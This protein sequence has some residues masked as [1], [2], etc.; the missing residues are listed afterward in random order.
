MSIHLY[1]PQR[2]AIET[3]LNCN[4]G[5]GQIIGDV[6]EDFQTRT[7]GGSR[8]HHMFIGPRGIG[9]TTLLRLIAHHLTTDAD[10]AGRY[11]PVILAE[12]AYGV[13]RVSDLMV[14]IARILSQ[15]LDKAELTSTYEKVRHEE[16]DQRVVD[17]VLDALRD[18]HRNT[19]LSLVL[20][21]ENC[22]RFLERQKRNRQELHLLR[23]IMM[24]EVWLTGIF[25][26]PTYLNAITDHREPFFEFFK[27]TTLGEL[28]P[29]ELLEMLHKL[30]EV[31][32][33]AKFREY[34]Q[35]H[36]SRIRAL[37]HFTGGNPRLA[38]MLYD[39]VTNHDITGV[40]E[41]LDHLLDQITPF[42]QDRM[43]DLSDQEAKA[44]EAMSLIPEGCLPKDLAKQARLEPGATRVLLSRLENAGYI[45]REKRSDRKT[46]YYIPERLFRIWNAMNNSRGEKRKL[47][48]LVDFFSAWYATEEE[49]RYTWEVLTEKLLSTVKNSEKQNISATLEYLS[50]ISSISSDREKYETF[51]SLLSKTLSIGDNNK[52]TSTLLEILKT[53]SDDYELQALVLIYTLPIL[54]TDDMIH[55]EV[56]NLYKKYNDM[57]FQSIIMILFQNIKDKLQMMTKSL[58]LLILNIAKANHRAILDAILTLGLFHVITIT[59]DKYHS[60][61]MELLSP[62]LSLIFGRYNK[63]EINIFLYKSDELFP[64]FKN[65][66]PYA[67]KAY[68]YLTNK[69]SPAILEDLSPELREAAML[70]VKAFDSNPANQP[71]GAAS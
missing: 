6:L 9:K 11:L 70:L 55:K 23:K 3:L 15:D 40:R 67:T 32:D 16:D 41:E 69:R 43:K 60:H 19:G 26:S 53:N 7:A 27:V 37:Y 62:I 17:T 35:K 63:N 59:N 52:I 14:E 66:Y 10:L 65:D 44:L 18:F 12:E 20:M 29:D 61:I 48:Y 45:R 22:H 46:V 71:A 5:R 28:S 36:S 21:F 33:N 34:L 58:E 49:R 25:T 1:R 13:T 4:V 8:Q 47:Q 57:C 42:Y 50:Y 51:T 24:E 54:V 2:T 56:Y 30:T 38:V 64:I 31:E 68:E 39:L